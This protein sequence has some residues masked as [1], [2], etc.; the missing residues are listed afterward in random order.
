MFEEQHYLQ[1]HGTGMGTQMAPSYANIFMGDLDRKILTHM[2]KRPDIWCRNIDD[3]F[4]IWSHGEESLI[5]FIEQ[6]NNA[7]SKIQ[8]SVE[9]SN[10]SI[11]FLDVKG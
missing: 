9:W 3:V 4:V 2:D 1:T 5:E 6:I 8:F 11:A 10:T 7:H